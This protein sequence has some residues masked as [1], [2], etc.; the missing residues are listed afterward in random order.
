MAGIAEVG[1]VPS[2]PYLETFYHK[3]GRD[4]RFANV[5]YCQ[6]NS[7]VSMESSGTQLI[8]CL[9]PLDAP[10]VYD[11]S[12]VLIKLTVSILKQDGTLPDTSAM[13]FPV[14][15]SC[16][17]CFESLSMKINDV[18]ISLCEKYYNYKAYIQNLISF[19][20]EV[21]DTNLYLS[22]WIT[23]NYTRAHGIGDIEPTATNQAMLSRN[24]WFREDMEEG[25]T[26]PYSKEGYTMITPL[27]HDLYGCK[28]L[29]PPGTK[30]SFTL[31]KAADGWYLM[32][33]ADSTDTNEY[34]FQISNCTLYAKVVTLNDPI[35]RSLKSRLEKE[36][37]LFH[38][39]QLSMKP[40]L[41]NAHSILYESNNLFPDSQQPVRVYFMLVRNSSVGPKSYKRNPYSF[42]RALKVKGVDRK[43]GG[44]SEQ[45]LQLMQMQL[46]QQ[47]QQ[48]NLEILN[49]LRR[50]A[51]NAKKRKHKH[52]KLQQMHQLDGNET[53]GDPN[54]GVLRL[55]PGNRKAKGKGKGKKSVPVTEDLPTN[56][57]EIPP[58]SPQPTTSNA[59]ERNAAKKAK[60]AIKKL[61]G[62]ISDVES[63]ESE[64]DT[65]HSFICPDSSSDD[66]T[67]DDH[68][69][70]ELLTKIYQCQTTKHVKPTLPPKPQGHKPSG[71]HKSYYE[72]PPKICYVESFEL[73][74]NSKTIDQFTIPATKMQCPD[75]YMRFLGK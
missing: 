58:L 16:L 22:G 64:A 72:D 75:S 68:T 57:Q 39:R 13:V 51:D 8:F 46:L 49:E 17:S 33:P 27:K 2:I 38:Y 26:K 23:D 11:V 47:Q 54:E 55:L 48:Q 66:D 70:D 67:C 61:G 19:N 31:T 21:K 41:I 56:L 37:I 6:F 43:S 25:T 44:P 50:M 4:E 60:V 1:T 53:E 73:D 59:A 45:S 12:D 62:L 69:E 40:E 52:S 32:K 9:N 5:Q 36:R 28:V 42:I 14:N 15:S 20:E 65:F 29:F 63:E 35:Y 3:L 30:I 74:I 18:P 10:L 24:A 34:K 7:I 71:G